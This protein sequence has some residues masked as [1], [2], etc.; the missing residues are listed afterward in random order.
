MNN[1]FLFLRFCVEREYLVLA[2]M[3]VLSV[4]MLQLI[5][6]VWLLA[7]TQEVRLYQL[8]HLLINK[9]D[10]LLNVFIVFSVQFQSS[11]F[12]LNY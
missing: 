10:Y 11:T 8:S 2:W 12:Y 4:Y 6:G 9:E 3:A 1:V 5:M 7:A